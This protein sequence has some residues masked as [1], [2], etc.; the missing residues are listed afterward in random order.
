MSTATETIGCFI[1]PVDVLYLRG[2]K[3]FGAAGDHGEALMPPWPSMAAGALRSH[4]LVKADVSLE[5]YALGIG[6]LLS[7]ELAALGMPDKPGSFRLA[8]FSAAQ[9]VD[10]QPQPV[11]PI[12]ADQF[13]PDP[14]G[15]NER[16]E[17]IIALRPTKLPEG[18]SCSAHTSALPLLQT[19][20]QSKPA[21]GWLLNANGIDAWVGGRKLKAD[22]HL[23]H[24]REVWRTETR[25]GIARDLATGTAAEGRIYTSEVVA[26]GHA[27]AAAEPEGGFLVLLA[28]LERNA[29][30]DFLQAALLRLGGDGRAAAAG[31]VDWQPPEPDWA[32]IEKERA[33]RIMLTTPGIFPGGWRLPG[34][35][36]NGTWHGPRGLKGRLH[37]AAAPRHQVVSG[38]DLAALNRPGRNAP[39]TGHPKPAQKAAP[40]GSVYWLEE[41][42]GDIR[43]GLSA[44]L[45]EG[46]WACMSETDLN[47]WSAQ[48]RAEGFGNCLIG[49]PLQD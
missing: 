37:A 42:E 43:G 3:L 23:V 44:L 48:R 4:M 15:E 7:Q 21:S 40:V 25:L 6:G 11:V 29:A 20:G 28:G 45:R 24:Q 38:W 1:H 39:G 47:A 12:P 8:W 46:L 34:V 22:E 35:G 32:R 14:K 9:L 10:G 36:E 26:F 33:C 27:R 31:L 5:D 13:V 41:L 18:I 19:K 17:G 2:N 16:P 49:A 30:T